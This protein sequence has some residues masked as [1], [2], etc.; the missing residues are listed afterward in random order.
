[1]VSG[2]HDTTYHTRG[3]MVQ[4]QQ[5]VLLWQC[6]ARCEVLHNF[7][8]TLMRYD[9]AVCL[10]KHHENAISS[11]PCMYANALVSSS[12]AT[13]TPPNITHHLEIPQGPKSMQPFFP[14]PLHHLIIPLH[15]RRDENDLRAKSRPCILQQLH[16]IRATA[17]LF[18]V[19]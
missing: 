12:H 13:P 19:P 7:A 15:I 11:L 2:P 5:I 9:A 8:N 16:R 1:V 4:M 18:R 3:T 10:P 14:T 17:T 6:D